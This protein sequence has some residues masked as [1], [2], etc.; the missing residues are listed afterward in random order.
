LPVNQALDKNQVGNPILLS[1]QRYAGLP[2][3]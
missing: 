3:G 2:S 1:I